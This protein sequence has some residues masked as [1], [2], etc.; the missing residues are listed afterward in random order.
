MAAN[1]PRGLSD[2]QI[3][4]QPNL[5]RDARPMWIQILDVATQAPALVFQMFLC[6][7]I[8][9]LFPA[10]VVPMFA[11]ALVISATGFL[12]HRRDRL[13]LRLPEEA[14]CTDYSNPLPGRR[15]FAKASGS[16]AMGNDRMSGK[17][18]W[19]SAKDF[20]THMLIFGTTGS[21][22]TETLVSL[23]TNALYN[24][25]GLAYTD[26]KAAPK[27]VTQIYSIARFMGRDDDFRVLNYAD[28]N[29]FPKI[30]TPW[31]LSNTN[32][33]FALGSA[34]QLTNVLVNL[35]PQAE[36][37]NAIFS[38][39]AQTLINGVM[40]C[41]VELR[42]R[43]EIQLSISKIREYLVLAKVVELAERNDLSTTSST[44][45]KSALTGFG[46]QEGR[47][48]QQQP[49]SLPEQFGYARS[50]FGLS[51]ASLSDT[52]G[53]IHDTPTG[54]V[55][56]HDIIKQRRIVVTALPSLQKAPQELANLG[57]I[58][59]SAQRNAIS[60]GL[61]EEIEGTIEE[62]IESLPVDP[63]I[64]FLM[65]VDEYAAIPTPGFAEVLTQGRGLGIGAIVASQDYPGIKKAD[66]NGAQQ[67]VANTMMK[68]IMRLEDPQDTWTLV[69]D[70]A[71]EADVMKV[72]SL[73]QGGDARGD[74]TMGGLSYKPGNDVRRNSMQR[75]HIRDLQEQT[76]GE[77]HATFRGNLIRG[78][79]FHADPPL[80]REGEARIARMLQVVQPKE[81]TLSLRHGSLRRALDRMKEL[82]AEGEAPEEPEA[83]PEAVVIARVMR[84]G[85][86]GEMERAQA[87]I[88][89]FSRAITE[90]V[91]S[92]ALKG[93][94]EEREMESVGEGD[95]LDEAL[96]SLAPPVDVGGA[97]RGD[98]D[99]EVHGVPATESDGEPGGSGGT[100]R[101][102]APEVRDDLDDIDPFPPA[103]TEDEREAASGSDGAEEADDG[104]ADT[105]VAPA[106]SDDDADEM[107]D[108]TEWNI[109]SFLGKGFEK[110]VA[111]V[112]TRASGDR[113]EG[114]RKARKLTRTMEGHLMYPPGE[115]PEADEETED[116][117]TS[118]L[119][120]MVD[121]IGHE[122]E[123]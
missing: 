24:G 47:S 40:Y 76:E 84:S 4:G 85:W 39:N 51:L 48:L 3:E 102:A 78:R 92:L 53:H 20:L 22:K 59:L 10:W 117:L 50:Y 74:K 46:W 114:E 91:Q 69:R 110:D 23:C 93:G 70:M 27:L 100:S 34:E 25:G 41:L 98:P 31:R 58:T 63:D 44:A 81:T 73:Y 95:D 15:G 79:V 105:K 86:K 75:V 68:L 82:I 77:F 18:L 94:A 112:E 54:E 29:K 55:D 21:G 33:P 113:E 28:S 52:Y 71:G 11:L 49:R 108:L 97:R 66:E 61:G 109:E 123:D 9:F 88:D 60:V 118:Q 62:T 6:A 13:P 43:G 90:N 119:Q 56:W 101:R 16:F 121:R 19:L 14:D 83:P 64:P 72:D 106:L 45:V 96:D 120:Q 5:V 122:D 80:P 67:I 12:S 103:E 30:G 35:I 2:E 65:L 38:Q 8:G 99:A 32:N 1:I 36:G 37:S 89:M 57:K 111:E 115:A 87:S 116:D 17:E 104:G 42:D 26:P 7:A 107:S